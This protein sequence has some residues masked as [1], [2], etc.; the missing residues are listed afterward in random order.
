MRF[1]WI[2]IFWFISFSFIHMH[3]LPIVVRTSFKNAQQYYAYS[4]EEM[5]VPLGDI[6]FDQKLQLK[7]IYLPTKLAAEGK[8]K[9]ANNGFG[10]QVEHYY[11]ASLLFDISLILHEHVHDI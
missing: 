11:L 3:A 2:K 10:S 4:K 6:I 9:P 1:R 7:D 5:S 8:I